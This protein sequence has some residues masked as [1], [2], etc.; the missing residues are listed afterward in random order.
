MS[1]LG[2]SITMPDLLRFASRPGIVD[3]ALGVPDAAPPDAALDAAQRAMREGRNRYIDSR[4][5]GALRATW[6]AALSAE[7]GRELDA[8]RDI[9]VT[10]GAT[11]GVFCA[12]S[13]LLT[14]GDEVVVFEPYYPPHVRTARLLGG[15]VRA[16]RLEPPRWRLTAEA[17][18]RAITPRTRAVLLSS[19]GNPTGKVFDHAELSLI[20][21]A[22]RRAGA[23]VIVDETYA[24]F[25]YRD[26]FVSA[27]QADPD[28][29][30]VVAV[31][32]ASKALALSGW[33]IGLVVAPRGLMGRI[34]AFSDCSTL[35]AA[36]PL[37]IGVR[38]AM[39][40]GPARLG[41][42]RQ[43]YGDQQERLVTGLKALGFEPY[44]AS[45]GM[46]FLARIPAAVA[47]EHRLVDALVSGTGVLL[48]PGHLFT[49]ASTSRLVRVCFARSPDTIGRGLARLAERG[50][51]ALRGN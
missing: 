26:S 3:L 51:T 9:T 23:T 28:G 39:D 24:D 43:R 31:R 12:L 35:G 41:S 30:H 7:I 15:R 16:I 10:V 29:Q 25:C 45:G 1:D 22:C 17:L 37:Q 50:A 32:G 19:P 14:P 21:D 42:L 48:A 38:A 36:T 33:R 46:F 4:G 20:V 6:A 47:D 49:E 44:P 13:A 2:G 11:G 8:E 40:E 18:A 5:D 27:L 34:R